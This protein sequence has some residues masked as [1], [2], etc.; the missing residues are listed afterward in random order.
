MVRRRI[1]LQET[2]KKP[3]QIFLGVNLVLQN[4]LNHRMS[5]IQVRIVGILLHRDTLPPAPPEASERDGGSG[6]GLGFG[7]GGSGG[8]AMVM[9]GGFEGG[10]WLEVVEEVREELR[11]AN[12]EIDGEGSGLEISPGSRHCC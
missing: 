7:V 6:L 9:V 3:S 2:P 11:S 8:E 5:E 1:Q 4:H 10:L 12:V